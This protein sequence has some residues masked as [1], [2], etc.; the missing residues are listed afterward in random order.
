[1]IVFETVGLCAGSRVRAVEREWAANV[2]RSQRCGKQI[3]RTSAEPKMRRIND[4]VL[5][6]KT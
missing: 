6:K 3:V 1:M 5:E 4:L 2:G